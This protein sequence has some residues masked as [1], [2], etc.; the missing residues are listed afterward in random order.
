MTLLL[1][2]GACADYEVAMSRDAAPSDDSGA[3]GADWAADTGGGHEP[4]DD[5]G[6]GS[7]EEDDF[8][9]LAPAVTNAYV[10]VA[11]T[12]RGTVTRIAVPELEVVTVEG[13]TD[14]T[15][16]TTTEDY[17]RAVVFNQGSDDV[18]IIDAETLDVVTV[19]VR[20]NLNHMVVSP[21][22]VWAIVYHDADKPVDPDIHDDGGIQSQNEISLVDLDGGVH[23]PMV[24]GFNPNDVAFTPDS[25]VA[26]VISDAYLAVL[27]LTDTSPSPELIEIA[28]DVLEA[29]AA[30]EVVINGEGTY[31]FVRQYGSDELV[32]VDLA[33]LWV[34]RVP[35]GSNPTDV[36]LTPDG[37]SIVVV[38]RASKE[39]A[40]FD[41]A[42][43][44]GDDPLMLDLPEDEVLGSV[45]FSP[46]N[47]QAVL[48]TTT[49][50]TDHYTSWDLSDDTFAV[51]ALGKPIDNMVVTPTG[52]SL[53]AFH[54]GDLDDASPEDS[55]Y[56]KPGLSLIDLTDFR[57]NL[58]IL[59]EE[60]SAYANAENGEVG[61]FIMEGHDTLAMLVYE[62]LLY[63]EIRL[64]SEPVH[65][66]VLP[67]STFAYV[68]QV[69]DLGRLTFFDPGDPLD[70]DDDVLETITGFELNSG[71]EH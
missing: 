13:G 42:D 19:P 34:D 46:D 57:S 44:L 55:D 52:G 22:G 33:T 25:L 48:Y 23:F 37:E 18:S 62:Q 70:H 29:P 60:P 12:S 20:D 39:L 59:P 51:R 35:A 4:D 31:A 15:V 3:S 11:N 56:G 68:N 64:K 50:N 7:E 41:A 8:L 6:L 30:E 36:D 40:I 16:G 58:L 38:A 28:E 49:T 47:T 21:D 66:G 53:M 71:I 45:L 26:T 63:E 5:D 54:S 27:D 17:T 67:D 24:V 65:V 32:V 61:F 69:H 14:P 9:K 1:L 43:P 10:F 2:L